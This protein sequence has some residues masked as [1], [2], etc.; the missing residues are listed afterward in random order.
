MWSFRCWSWDC[1]PPTCGARS[2]VGFYLC[3]RVR[4]L[5]HGVTKTIWCDGSAKIPRA[6]RCGVADLVADAAVILIPVG[7]WLAV[8]SNSAFR[9][10]LL[11]AWC[12]LLA[13]DQAFDAPVMYYRRFGLGA[14][15]DFLGLLMQVILIL[16][17]GV[18]LNLDLLILL[19]VCVTLFKA[20]VLRIRF[21]PVLIPGIGAAASLRA[22]SRASFPCI[23]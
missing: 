15:I 9:A 11:V 6:N 14:M 23:C 21:G 7:I 13:F 5:W 19:F 8:Q 17:I 1:I 22:A 2:L 4:I 16:L 10:F 20:V 18:R 3:T 12:A